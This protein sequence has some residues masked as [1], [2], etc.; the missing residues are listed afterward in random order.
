MTEKQMP[1][2]ATITGQADRTLNPL[3]NE[4]L[5]FHLKKGEEDFCVGL[6]DILKCLKF[7]EERGEV[8][9]IDPIWWGKVANLYCMEELQTF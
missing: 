2:Q 5:W 3:V 4:I 1:E 7:A 8:P 9:P 6:T